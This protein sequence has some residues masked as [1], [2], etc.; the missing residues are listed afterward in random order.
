MRP[1]GDEW[2]AAEDDGHETQSDRPPG[3]H[4]AEEVDDETPSVMECGVT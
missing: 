1:G 2:T 3:V 4:D